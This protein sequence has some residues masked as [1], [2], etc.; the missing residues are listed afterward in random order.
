MNVKVDAELC[1]GCGL[2]VNTSPDIFEM[3]E[4]KAVVKTPAVPAAQEESCKQSKDECPTEAI[5]IG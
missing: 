3:Q 2:C 5:I 1:V 4:D